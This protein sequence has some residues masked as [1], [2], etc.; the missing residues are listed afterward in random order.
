MRGLNDWCVVVVGTEEVLQPSCLADFR[1]NNDWPANSFDEQVCTSVRSKDMIDV[2]CRRH[3]EQLLRF[4]NR[5]SLS[6]SGPWSQ[7]FPTDA[8]RHHKDIAVGDHNNDLHNLNANIHKDD[9]HLNTV[10]SVSVGT[11]PNNNGYVTVTVPFTVMTLRLPLVRFRAG[12][13]KGPCYVHA[14]LGQRWRVAKHTDTLAKSRTVPTAAVVH[15][16][17]QGATAIMTSHELTPWCQATNVLMK[18]GHIVKPGDHVT[19]RNDV[20]GISVEC[21]QR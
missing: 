12:L 11:L 5:W 2:T 3:E 9:L 10:P 21:L 8:H 20:H 6:S 14:R 15:D 16:L 17:A 4:A 13:L 1:T 18:F 7:Q 19:I